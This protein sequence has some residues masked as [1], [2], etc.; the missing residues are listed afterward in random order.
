MQ[1]RSCSSGLPRWTKGR[2]LSWRQRLGQRRESLRNSAQ[3]SSGPT[4]WCI[5]RWR[6][7]PTTTPGRFKRRMSGLSGWRRAQVPQ[8]LGAGGGGPAPRTIRRAG[9]ASTTVLLQAR[10]NQA[11]RAADR[12]RDP[13]Q[14]QE[15]LL[16]T[17]LVQLGQSLLGRCSRHSSVLSEEARRS[18][19]LYGPRWRAGKRRSGRRLLAR[20]LLAT[21]HR[22]FSGKPRD[23]RTE[24]SGGSSA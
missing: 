12:V 1:G 8:P 6:K 11:G 20:R 17:V 24:A 15:V 23:R 2:F 13:R 5:A 21:A 18:R 19:P 3:T 9:N 7:T 10:P 14:R 22:C 4:T 16:R